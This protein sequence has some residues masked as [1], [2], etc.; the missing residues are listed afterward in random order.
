MKSVLLNKD[1]INK[2][3][4][5]VAVL[6]MIVV[7]T[8]ITAVVAQSSRL[9]T[10]ISLST[11]E[12]IR[13]K[14]A[15]RAGVESAI[16]VLNDDL[17]DSD[18][19]FDLWS[20]NPEDFNS[21][22]LDMCSYSVD[23]IDEA[24]KLNINT[25]TKDQLMYL[26]NMTEDIADSILDWRD[27]NDDISEAGAES[28]YYLEL[29]YGY[30]A[31]NGNFK[32]V[33]ELLLVKGVSAQLLYGGLTGDNFIPDDEKWISYL[34]CYSYELNKD[35]EGESRININNGDENGLSRHL[36]I[37]RSY[38]KWIVD[39]RPSSGYQSIAELINDDSPDK[40]AENA[41]S[42][43]DAIPVDKQTFGDIADRITVIDTEIIPGRININTASR[44][45]LFALFE[46]DEGLADDI[47]AYRRGLIDG[48]SSLGELLNV[49]SMNVKNA[50][51]Y[52]ARLTVRSS[53][54]TIYS[55]A[56][57]DTT[58]A[59]IRLEAV[60]AR[61]EEPT[62]ILYWYTGAKY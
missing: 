47:I 23:V 55:T 25:A 44:R 14:W 18:S 2:G 38:A 33:R 17:E 34:T 39:N 60:I 27:D 49:Q 46:G 28:G 41:E 19:L 20:E 9:D 54:F 3:L 7:M 12:R 48:M 51:K 5:L 32:T 45:V 1:K 52:F 13:C 4:V 15:C 56:K 31:R 30:E 8:I 37:P 57:A 6:W 42:S 16:A 35:A 36:E 29:P 61:N 11:A 58:G 40:P 59:A 43:N 22:P 50:Q 10:R 53:V 62:Q 24:S 21:V 26:P